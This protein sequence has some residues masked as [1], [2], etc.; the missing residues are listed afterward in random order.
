[1]N[2]LFTTDRQED[3][4]FLKME[5]EY[6]GTGA[7]EFE[8]GMYEYGEMWERAPYSY[9]GRIVA[10]AAPSG[11][12]KT[13]VALEYLKVVRCPSVSYLYAILT[14]AASRC[15]HLSATRKQHAR[16]R[17]AARRQSHH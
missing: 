15:L 5:S 13:K 2:T 6:V 3:R 12:G 4:L 10:I 17:V 11:L 7:R 16:A 8:R 14:F 9:H 1:M